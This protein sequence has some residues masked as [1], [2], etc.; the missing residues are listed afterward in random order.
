[1]IAI[2]TTLLSYWNSLW[3]YGFEFEHPE[4]AWYIVPIMLVFIF[5]LSTGQRVTGGAPNSI[6]ALYY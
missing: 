5:F 1:M 4:R 2:W 6:P 3:Q